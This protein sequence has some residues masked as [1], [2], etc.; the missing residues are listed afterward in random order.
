MHKCIC[1]KKKC[2]RVKGQEKIRILVPKKVPIS[3]FT[4]P[5]SLLPLRSP[6][7]SSVLAQGEAEK[8]RNHHQT[9]SN[10]AHLLGDAQEHFRDGRQRQPEGLDAPPP[11][12]H[13]SKKKKNRLQ[14]RVPLPSLSTDQSFT[15]KLRSHHLMC[16]AVGGQGEGG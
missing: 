15:K 6:K 8:G 5:T 12:P 14:R 1:F 13:E 3:R 11:E 4:D 10:G 7:F 2:I 9:V 16:K